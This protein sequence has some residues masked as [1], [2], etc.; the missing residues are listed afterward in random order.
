MI[1]SVWTGTDCT[2]LT[3]QQHVLIK[4]LALGWQVRPPNAEH[5]ENGVALHA[6]NNMTTR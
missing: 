5:G 6:L 1:S 3:A 4:N 2:E